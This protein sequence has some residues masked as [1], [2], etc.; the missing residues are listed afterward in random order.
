MS[1][2]F[3]CGLGVA[4][5]HV[6]D[7]RESPGFESWRPHMPMT[8]CMGGRSVGAENPVSK[9]EQRPDNQ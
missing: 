2:W 8:R 1:P 6:P 7:P 3:F 4:W 9:P 5:Q